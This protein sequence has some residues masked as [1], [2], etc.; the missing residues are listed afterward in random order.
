LRL[1]EQRPQRHADIL[2]FRG[3]EPLPVPFD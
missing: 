1:D 2:V 3:L